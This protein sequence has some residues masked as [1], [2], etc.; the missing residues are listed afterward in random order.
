MNSTLWIPILA[1][2]PSFRNP[3]SSSNFQWEP[4]QITYF[5]IFLFFRGGKN[6]LLSSPM[7]HKLTEGRTL[8]I[9]FKIKGS[10]DDLEELVNVRHPMDTRLG[11]CIIEA[12]WSQ[13]RVQWAMKEQSGGWQLT[14]TGRSP[15]SRP[16]PP[17][18]Q[19]KPSEKLHQAA[20]LSGKGVLSRGDRFL[21]TL[22]AFI[23]K[24]EGSPSPKSSPGTGVIQ[25]SRQNDTRAEPTTRR[26]PEAAAS[27]SPSS[28]AGNGGGTSAYRPRRAP[29]R[30]D[31]LAVLGRPVT[32]RA[33]A[34][35]GTHSRTAKA[36]SVG[37]GE[38]CPCF[39]VFWLS[40]DLL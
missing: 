10:K 8:L 29:S 31:G 19:R 22:T 13:A 3:N 6:G 7:T 34:L 23:L 24:P 14:E 20:T 35:P 11:D 38:A 27:P 18:Q 21:R 40:A 37:A 15:E 36:K 9:M 28:A 30:G 25:E 26:K 39:W 2:D 4:E 5:L 33:R 32:R 16:P 17:T 12:P 1:G